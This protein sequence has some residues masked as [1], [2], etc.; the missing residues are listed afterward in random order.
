MPYHIIYSKKMKRLTKINLAT[1]L[2]VVA[3]FIIFLFGYPD[4]SSKKELRAQI[5]YK[6]LRP[7]PFYSISTSKQTAI[8][9][10]SMF[11]KSVND[12]TFL[13]VYVTL[14]SKRKRN[15]VTY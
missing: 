6:D 8:N 10:F 9:L 15:F 11:D 2:Q 1:A 3:V 14:V 12:I 13:Q 4:C 5:V 7:V